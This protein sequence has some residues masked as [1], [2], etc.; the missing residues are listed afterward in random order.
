MSSLQLSDVT[1]DTGSEFASWD[2]DSP[3]VRH[4]KLSYNDS[5]LPRKARRQ[6]PSLDARRVQNRA[7]QRA[8]R[9]RAALHLK[10]VEEELASMKQKYNEL[11]QRY[12]EL[13]CWSNGLL[14]AL[15]EKD[16]KL[17]AAPGM[18]ASGV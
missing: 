11:V 14:S 16:P 4:P 5:S 6:G 15:L 17:E 13:N 1:F 7:A 2:L 3:V 18:T 9:Q 8:Y 10:A 12:G